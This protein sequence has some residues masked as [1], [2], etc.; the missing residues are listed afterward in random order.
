MSDYYSKMTQTLYSCILKVGKIL[1]ALIDHLKGKYIGFM[2]YKYV[3]RNIFSVD[4]L[5]G[6]TYLFVD[7][8]ACSYSFPF[9]KGM[10]F[11]FLFPDGVKVATDE[12]DTYWLLSRISICL[13]DDIDMVEVLLGLFVLVEEGWCGD[14]NEDIVPLDETPDDVNDPDIIDDPVIDELI[15]VDV[16]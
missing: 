5:I 11:S 3:L 8:D 13:G 9:L 1:R 2:L 7:S 15:L 16:Q 12:E 6:S 4:I 14:V 10:P